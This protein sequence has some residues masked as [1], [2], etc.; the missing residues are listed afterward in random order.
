MNVRF[1]IVPMHEIPEGFFII[2]DAPVQYHSFFLLCRRFNCYFWC[3]LDFL[4]INLMVAF[5]DQEPA[6]AFRHP[7]FVANPLRP[8]VAPRLCACAMQ[9]TACQRVAVAIQKLCRECFATGS[10]PAQERSF[11]MKRRY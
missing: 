6:R 1:L 11:I 5:P 9:R 10:A 3:R 2:R 4:L 8:A 7:D